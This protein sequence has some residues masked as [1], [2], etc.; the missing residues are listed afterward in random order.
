MILINYFSWMTRY[1][2]ASTGYKVIDDKNI[3]R[4]LK[5]WTNITQRK[6]IKIW[7]KIIKNQSLQRKDVLSLRDAVNFCNTSSEII[8]CETGSSS[9]YNK[10]I[11][12]NDFKNITYIGLDL[13]LYSLSIGKVSDIQLKC[14]NASVENIPFKDKSV[15]VVLD[16]ATLIHVDNYEKVLKEYIRIRRNYIILHSLTLYD[17]NKNLI[18]SKYAYG[19][20]VLENIFSVNF[21]NDFFETNG[22]EILA[23]F[24]GENYNLKD[25]I[26]V[27]TKSE[28]WVIGEK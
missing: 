12:Y 27:T 9:G 17:G 22:L 13:S 21:L 2:F 25:L 6:Q 5:T 14:I 28:T 10:N 23:K 7:E 11:F 18:L 8:V 3:E 4:E 24:S 15:N 16:G 26:G 19:Q 20:R 1:L